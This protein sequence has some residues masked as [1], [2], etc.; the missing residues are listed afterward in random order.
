[1]RHVWHSWGLVTVVFLASVPVAALLAW[2]WARMRARRGVSARDALAEALMVAGTAPWLAPLLAPNPNP[3]ATRRVILVPFTDLIEQ[4]GKGPRFVL[5][6][7]GGNLAVFAVL[8]F[9]L[10]IRY[11][12][13][14]LAAAAVAFAASTGVEVAQYVFDLHR[15]SSVDDVIINTTGA[16]LGALLS[17]RWWRRRRRPAG[18]HGAGAAGISPGERLPGA[19][20]TRR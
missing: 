5:I 4:I 9:V 11:R 14:A 6:E 13:G 17:R 10:P 1:M 12:V 7:V 16:V 18:R 19:G 3:L 15:V 2:G 20:S 8:G